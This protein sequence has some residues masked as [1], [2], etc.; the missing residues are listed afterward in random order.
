M[1]LVELI[2]SIKNGDIVKVVFDERGNYTVVDK[3]Y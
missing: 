2:E 3:T 1:S